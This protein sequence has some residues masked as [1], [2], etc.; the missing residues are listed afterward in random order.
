LLG[1]PSHADGEGLSRGKKMAQCVLILLTGERAELI[2][3]EAFD[4][5]VNDIFDPTSVDTGLL[6]KSALENYSQK[7]LLHHLAKAETT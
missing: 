7:R 1:P 3:A 6:R 5:D 4:S 2:V